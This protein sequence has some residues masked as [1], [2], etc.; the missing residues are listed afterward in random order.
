LFFELR[1]LLGNT[2]WDTGIS[3]PELLGYL[4]AA[5]AGRALDLG[6]GTGTNSIRMAQAGWSVVGVDLSRLAIRRARRKARLAGFHVDFRRLDVAELAGLIGPFDLALDIGCFHMLA[7][8][9]RSTYA[10][11]LVQLLPPGADYLLYT[12]LADPADADAWPPDEIEIQHTFDGA[13]SV[14]TRALGMDRDRTSAWYHMR[15]KP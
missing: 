9:Q 2:P 11:R 1:Y 3:P 8:E 13:F 12:F 10:R 4:Q 6:C 5:P 14:L 15:R 7:A